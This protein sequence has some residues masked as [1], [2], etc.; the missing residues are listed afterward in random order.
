[1]VDGTVSSLRGVGVERAMVV[2]Q[3]YSW[4][5]VPGTDVEVR[6]F[7]NRPVRFGIVDSKADA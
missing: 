6:V 7:A 1:M 2:E 5:R 4:T 3:S